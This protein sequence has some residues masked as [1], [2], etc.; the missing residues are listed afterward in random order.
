MADIYNL[1]NV[2][3]VT[4]HNTT[5]GADWLQPQGVLLARFLKIGARFSF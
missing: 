4:Q 2:N 1:L 5:F 3:P